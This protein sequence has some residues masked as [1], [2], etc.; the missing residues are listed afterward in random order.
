M[1]ITIEAQSMADPNFRGIPYY[2]WNIID[3][4]VKA[5]RHSYAISFFDYN[6]E[7]NNSQKILSRFSED[8]LSNIS[9]KECNSYSY[10]DLISRA[11]SGFE[12]IE[13]LDYSMLYGKSDGIWHFPN[14]IIIGAELP[15]KSVVTVNDVM[16]AI[17]KGKGYWSEATERAFI[18]SHEYLRRREDIQIIAISNSTKND[19]CNYFNINED[20]VHVVYD[21]YDDLTCYP[22][23]NKTV[24]EKYNIDTNYLLY[25]GAL[26][27][28]KGIMDIVEA[29][30]NIQKRYD[31]KLVLAGGLWKL[32]EDKINEIKSKPFADKIIFT[33][34][35]SDEEKRALMSSA[36]MFLFPSEYEGFGIP[37]LEAMACGCPVITTNSSSIPEVCGDAAIMVDVNNA[38]QLKDSI[39]DLLDDKEKRIGMA[40]RGLR[41]CKEFSWEKTARETELVYELL[42]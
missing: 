38:E 41:R 12:K 35:V 23:K 24:L 7:R 33:G 1:N 13:Y 14:S 28:R 17:Y 6:K 26:D 34:Y 2:T 20:R 31:V 5:N 21:A 10:K 40:E 4:L 27:P 29:F 37:I 42:R 32:Y 30:E 39:E 11:L 25:I 36:E 18:N 16:P 22:E 3:R 9:V 19:L 8:V 15:E